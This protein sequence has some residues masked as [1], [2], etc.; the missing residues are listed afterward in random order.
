MSFLAPFERQER[1][2]RWLAYVLAVLLLPAI[3][4]LA[5]SFFGPL[6]GFVICTPVLGAYGAWLL[7]NHGGA[8][9]R[10]LRWLALRKVNGCYHAFDDLEVRAEWCDR[11]CRVAAPDIFNILGEKTSDQT[12]RR[13]EI[14]YGPRGFFQ[15][16]NG[17]WW[18]GEAAIL[19]YL[20]RRARKP[21]HKA[22]RLQLWLER[23]VFPPLHKKAEIQGLA[24]APPHQPPLDRI[25]S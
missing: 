11:H 25:H 22:H 6:I 14:S 24:P 13:L 15:D 1:N 4:A 8:G 5:R 12:L 9:Y 10:G 7:L 18:F 3:Y 23:E 21:G 16:D 20:K 17:G 19:Q 2:H